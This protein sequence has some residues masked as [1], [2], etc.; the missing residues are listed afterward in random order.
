[1]TP[2]PV[3]VSPRVLSALANPVIYHYYP[4]FVELFDETVKKVSQV[5]RIRHGTDVLI[6]QAEAVLG[7]E[8]AV[9]NTVN[10][11]ERFWSLKMVRLENSL[12][13]L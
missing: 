4:G 10:P 2:G 11:G 6:L 3:E 9:V 13:I 12:Q 1:M 5:F 8:A 7:L